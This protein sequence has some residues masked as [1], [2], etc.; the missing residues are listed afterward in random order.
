M[1][2]MI[3]AI[4][5]DLDGTLLDTLHDLADSVNHVL[6]NHGM[7]NRTVDEIRSFIGNGVPTLISR[8]VPEGT[9]KTVTDECVRE[10]A[11]YYKDHADIKTKPYDGIKELLETLKNKGIRTAVVTNKVE[12]AAEI[13]C[14]NKFG[15]VFDCVI[16]DN[17]K[18]RLK[19]H[20]DNVFRAIDTLGCEKKEVLY[21]GDSDVDMITA[22]NAG[23]ESIGVTWGFRSR[24]VLEMA[25]AESIIDHPSELLDIVLPD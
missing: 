6:T 13:L 21:V 4:I 22:E 18:D 3:K 16:G 14:N 10:M 23:L 5:F 24:M 11:E 25:G 19:P 2:T 15:G 12:N 8:S 17:G 20:P 7:K 9:D 1:K